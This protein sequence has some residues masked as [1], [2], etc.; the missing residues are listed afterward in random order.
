MP[1]H[2]RATGQQLRHL[3]A[4][5]HVTLGSRAAACG[6]HGLHHRPAAGDEP[7]A[8]VVRAGASGPSMRRRQD[9]ERVE[10]PAAG[11]GQ[12]VDEPGQL[13]VEHDAHPREEVVRLAELRDTRP[14]PVVPGVGRRSG[15]LRRPRAPSRRG[16]RGP[17]SSPMPAR[18]RCHRRRRSA[19]W[20]TSL[21]HPSHRG[22]RDTPH[23]RPR[24]SCA[25]RVAGP[26]H[27]RA[28]RPPEG[29]DLSSGQRD[30]EGRLQVGE[31]HVDL[32]HETGQ[33]GG[34]RSGLG[35]RRDDG[36]R[37]PAPVHGALEPRRRPGCGAG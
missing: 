28:G 23:V 12:R 16:R 8:V 32:E 35:Q 4:P 36:R 10:P 9:G 13:G 11:I 34:R 3:H 25:A 20:S 24:R 33:V 37:V 22:G 5:L 31:G 14:R 18:S 2:G 7:E 30:H 1:A 19:P 15:R 21:P 17:A 29:A 6:D 27:E 26:R